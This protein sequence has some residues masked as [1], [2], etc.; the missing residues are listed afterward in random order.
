MGDVNTNQN[1][2]AEEKSLKTPDKRPQLNYAVSLISQVCASAGDLELGLSTASDKNNLVAAI[3][4]HDHSTIF[5]WLMEHFSYQGVSDAA[6]R[7]F[8][9]QNGRVT[10]AEVSAVARNPTCPKLAN[11]WQFHSCGYKKTK[12]V[13]EEPRHFRKCALP[14][15]KLRNGRLNQTAL[16]LFLFIR[17]VAGG[18]IVAWINQEMEAHEKSDLPSAALLLDPMRNIC[19]VSDK[20]LSMV[21][22]TFLIKGSAVYPRWHNLGT[23]MI[24]VDSLVHNF[25]HRTGI[26]E[27]TGSQHLYGPS[28]YRSG[29]CADIIQSVAQNIDARKFN[30]DYP[31]VFPR[32]VQH[33]IWRFCAQDGLGVCN[34]N[35]IDDRRRCQNAFCR[36]FTKCDRKRLSV[37]SRVL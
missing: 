36:L 28:C 11:Y 25:M 19:G 16:S 35:R 10:L 2:R 34:G 4:S 23:Y 7:G 30:G 13:C 14:S 17:D 8:M 5:E 22:S 33:A 21:L 3:R 37:K 27:R 6:A 29:G 31:K 26:L 1:R 20:V 12:G 32:F 15:L 9:D 18:D 24:A